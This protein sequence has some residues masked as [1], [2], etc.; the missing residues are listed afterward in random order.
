MSKEIEK[1]VTVT[2]FMGSKTAITDSDG[3]KKPPVIQQ[4]TIRPIYRRSQDIEKWRAA[5]R[6]AEATIP[7]RTELYDLYEDI[8]LDAHL[9]SVIDKRIMAVTNV[10][11][12]FLDTNNKEVE[13]MNKFIDTPE[14][15][16][17]LIEIMQSKFWGYSMIEFDFHQDGTIGIFN[18]PR[19]HIRPELGLI[20]YEQTG[21][22]GTDI[23]SGVYAD[24]VLEVGKEKDLGLLLSAAQYVIYKRGNFGDW[25]QFAEVFGMPLIDAVWDGF[26][27]KQRVLLQEALNN[28]GSGGQIVRP[29]GTQLQFLQGGTNNPTGDLYNNFISVC[30]A[31]LS[32]LILGQ[33][34]TTESSA[35]SG[36]AQASVHA[37]TENDINRNDLAF[38]TRILNRRVQA[39]LKANGIAIEGTFMVQTKSDNG[40]NLE[41]QLNIE[42]RL[43]NEAKLPIS[44]EHFYEKYGI[45]K[46]ADYDAQKAK[47]EAQAQQ[48]PLGLSDPF[49]NAPIAN[50]AKIISLRD[51]YKDCDCGCQTAWQGEVITLTDAPNVNDDFIEKVF[52]DELKDGQIHEGYYFRVAQKL[53]EAVMRGLGGSSFKA[54]DYRNTLKAYLEENIFAFSAAK[55]FAKMQ[56]FKSKMTDD[57]GDVVSYNAFRNAVI[58]INRAFD[59]NYLRAEYNS[60]ISMAQ[61]ADKWQSLQQYELLEYRAVIDNKVRKS[62]KDLNGKIFKSDDPLLNEIFPPNDWGCRCTMIPAPVG[63]K[64]DKQ[65]VLIGA[66]K[67]ANVKPYFKRNVG[68]SKM[69]FDENKHPYMQYKSGGEPNNLLAQDN[70]NL[71]SVKEI[72]RS[73]DFPIA[74]TG[75]TTEEVKKWFAENSK[76]GVMSAK[77]VDNIQIDLGKN[78]LEKLI[79]DPTEERSDRTS[80]AHIFKDVIENPNEVW[81]HKHRGNLQHVYIKYYKG[82]AYTAIIKDKAGK[83]EFET[84]HKNQSP[85]SKRVGV[86]KYRK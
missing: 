60:A 69:I 43:L 13:A 14:F 79:T 48:Q 66:T 27:E 42:L 47:L 77:T 84:F 1:R 67:S 31:E 61:S 36:Y 46:P 63:A 54:T 49:R 56:F 65:S 25:A 55:T 18:I 74:P 11:W 7:R 20:T 2:G 85:E 21:D 53:T 73:K 52:K 32:K 30:N 80:Y 72:L 41:Q 15:E 33:T 19:K 70:Y 81:A 16:T 45:E 37:D 35:S 34:E 38:V 76:N 29:A 40:L 58:P 22:T 83:M 3:Y 12:T 64:A 75:K 26:D 17:L 44:D 59:D 28:M 10:D 4:L 9:R 24:T 78:F 6:T 8:L 68:K 39:I 51:F 23:R 57:K 62:H 71:R 86:L 5:M 50:G 82:K